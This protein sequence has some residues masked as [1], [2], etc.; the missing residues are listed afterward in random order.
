MELEAALLRREHERQANHDR[1]E[2]LGAALLVE[3]GIEG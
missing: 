3:L 1:S 2:E